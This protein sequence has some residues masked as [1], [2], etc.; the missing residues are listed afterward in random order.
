MM[1]D[2]W[3]WVVITL[4][5][6]NHNIQRLLVKKKKNFKKKTFSGTVVYVSVSSWIIRWLDSLVVCYFV[7]LGF[8]R[9][10]VR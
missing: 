9:E 7:I 4:K 5:L 8:L 10:W 3:H 1:K 6:H 2:F